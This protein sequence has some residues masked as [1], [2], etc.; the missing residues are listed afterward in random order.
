MRFNKTNR[1]GDDVELPVDEVAERFMAIPEFV[2]WTTTG[3]EPLERLLMRWVSDTLGGWDVDEWDALAD[4]VVTRW[5][6]SR[7]RNRR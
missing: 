7:P 3:D 5:Q 1:V 2:A 4:E 6:L